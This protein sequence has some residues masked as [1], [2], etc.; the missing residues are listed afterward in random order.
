MV[1]ELESPTKA[2]ATFRPATSS[3]RRSSGSSASRASGT[4]TKKWRVD[5]PG[6]GRPA[7]SP[8]WA[9]GTGPGSPRSS[10][11][12]RRG[13]ASGY[14]PSLVPSKPR[15]GRSDQTPPSAIFHIGAPDRLVAAGDGR[16]NAMS[17]VRINAITV[18]ADRVDEF[19]RRFAA[20]AG[21]GGEGARLRDLRALRPTDERDVYP[22]LHALA[23]R[24][25]LPGLGQQP[26]VP[27]RAQGPQHGRPGRDGSELWSLR[28]RSSTRT[29]RP[30]LPTLDD[31][32]P[33]RLDERRPRPR[34][35]HGAGRPVR[36]RHRRRAGRAAAGVPEPAAALG[37]TSSR[38]PTDAPASTSSS[39][40]TGA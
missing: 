25:R 21:R 32:R 13:G 37:E 18:P 14:F 27:A 9:P 38:W 19:E 11:F 15:T 29:R 3:P 30:R 7:D 6:Q 26:R 39:R 17:V 33:D 36:D 23:D 31:R 34:R 2:R 8:N 5:G 28:R 16:K 20:R 1:R 12:P 4:G 40:A 35:P 24:G 10:R 22:R